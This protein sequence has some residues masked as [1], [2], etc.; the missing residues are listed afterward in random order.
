[1]FARLWE[2]EITRRKFCFYQKEHGHLRPNLRVF[3]AVLILATSVW[4][5]GCGGSGSTPAPTPTPTPVPT[6]T[7]A[8]APQITSLS[9]SSVPAGSAAFTLSVTGTNFLNTSVVQW[10][11]S[12]RPTTFVSSTLL[13]ASIGAADVTTAG[14]VVVS[15]ATPGVGTG[16]VSGPPFTVAGT[17]AP[18]LNSFLPTSAFV[19]APALTLDLLGADFTISS[20][21]LWNGSPRQTVFVSTTHLQ[22]AITVADLSAV[23]TASVSVSNP[24]PGGGTS[25]AGQFTISPNPLPSIFS[26]SPS[27]AEQGSAAFTLTVN[28]SNFV[29]GSTVQWN[30]TP[31]PTT[32]VSGTQLTAQ[33]G[34]ADIATFGNATVTVSN[35]TPGGGLS[36]NLAFGVTFPVTA[37]DQASQDLVYDPLQK[38]LYLS[39]PGTAAT[40]PN[41]ITI[42]D[43]VSA[44]VTG[45]VFAGSNPNVL[46]ISGDSTLLYAGMDGSSSVQRFTLPTLTPDISFPLG[47]NIFGPMTALDIQVAPGAPHTTALTLASPGVSPS[48]DFGI[49]IM[50]DATARPTIAKGFGPGG[51]GGVLYDS[52]QWGANATQLFAGNNEDTGF[53]FYTLAVDATGVVLTHDF[54]GVLPAFGQR[55]HFEPVTGFIY[56]DQGQVVNPAT[57][58]PVGSFT[59]SGNGH[60]VPDGASNA[61]Y[62]LVQSFSGT[63]AVQLL[64]FDLTHFTLT[65]TVP[66]PSITGNPRDLVRWGTNGLAFNTDAGKLYVLSNVP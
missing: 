13:Q 62:F 49:E 22:A 19:N 27:T 53:D 8:P 5:A 39:V 38:V 14:T 36:G 60:M 52:L 42:V 55:I 31:R 16:I 33:I 45:S 34:A 12:T 26:I 41:T 35:P 46:A 15:V 9:P 37:V 6:P 64:K 10:N 56:S 59:I 66:L 21:V 11:G 54:P 51:G 58:A 61:A 50:D 29:T 32:F 65:T 1:M 25:A 17:P 57:G 63:V 47:S 28:G 43:P 3:T 40:N 20:V 4:L 23:G 2:F 18:I 30:G 48:A 44:T 7:P 24:P